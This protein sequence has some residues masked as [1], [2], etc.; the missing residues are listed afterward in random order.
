MTKHLLI[1]GMVAGGFDRSGAFL[2]TVSHSGRGVFS[3]G[4]WQRVAR[5]GTPIY[6]EAGSVLGIGPISGE[7][8]P[9]REIDY[10]SGVLEFDSPDRK[11][12]LR[13]SDGTL[14][15]CSENDASQKN[16]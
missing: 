13:Y 14:T 16:A 9:V 1:G 5:D 11:W 8:I 2:L 10:S 3:V 6:P 4:T 12:S 15:V 7:K